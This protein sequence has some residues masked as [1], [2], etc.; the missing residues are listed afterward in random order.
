MLFQNAILSKYCFC[1]HIS[2]QYDIKV[3]AIYSPGTTVSDDMVNSWRFIVIK[4]WMRWSLF[5]LCCF[6]NTLTI[7]ASTQSKVDQRRIKEHYIKPDH[8][9]TNLPSQDIKKRSVFPT[10]CFNGNQSNRCN[11]NRMKDNENL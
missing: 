8:R 10:L 5:T 1:R 6:Q 2:H 11:R 3:S 4:Y 9:K 7:L